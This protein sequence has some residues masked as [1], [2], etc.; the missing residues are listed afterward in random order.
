MNTSVLD[1]V[2]RTMETNQTFVSFSIVWFQKENLCRPWPWPSWSEPS[3]AAPFLDLFNA[4][5]REGYRQLLILQIA[6][7]ICETICRRT[8][9]WPVE[10]RRQSWRHLPTCILHIQLLTQTHKSFVHAWIG[11][12]CTQFFFFHK[13]IVWLQ[14]PHRVTLCGS[15]GRLLSWK[16]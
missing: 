9:G 1:C 15:E 10:G 5:G 11:Y 6:L 12:T 13:Q 8:R 3:Q 4:Q 16:G 14:N 2:A 7:R